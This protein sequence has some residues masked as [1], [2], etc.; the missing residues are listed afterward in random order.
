VTSLRLIVLTNPVE[1]RENEFN[2]WYS[3]RHLDDVLNVAGFRAAQRFVFRAGKLSANAG[4][5]YLAIYE[6]EGAT[7]EEAEAALLA[8][9]ARMELMPI[10]SAMAR[11]RATWWFEAITDRVE[12]SV[13]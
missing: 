2:D 3:G 11:E 4:F 5:Q 13:D 7:L 8:A 1:G 12:A 6:V 10:S 9:A